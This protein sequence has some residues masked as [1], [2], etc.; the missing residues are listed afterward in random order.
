MS[1]FLQRVFLVNGVLFLGVCGVVQAQNPLATYDGL[2]AGDHLGIGMSRA[3]DVDLD[4]HADYMVAGNYD[5]SGTLHVGRVEVRSGKTGAMLFVFEGDPAAEFGG[6]GIAVAGGGDIDAD[7]IPD[8]VVGDSRNHVSDPGFKSKVWVYSGKDGSTILE[9][10]GVANGLKPNSLAVPGDVNQDG[11]A[12]IFVGASTN[13][14]APSVPGFVRVYS[15]KDG[16]MLFQVSSSKPKDGFGETVA[17]AG[18]VDGDG[19]SDLLIGVKN[20]DTNGFHAGKAL[21]YS[22]KTGAPIHTILGELG[23]QL[24]IS[25][26]GAGDLDADGFSDFIVGAPGKNG[27]KAF[28]YSGKDAS[29]LRELSSSPFYG[30]GTLFGH[31]VASVGDVN[32]DGLGDILVSSPYEGST[33]SGEPGVA[34]V[35]SGKDGALLFLKEAQTSLEIFGWGA[36]GVGDADGDGRDDFLVG[37][38]N[39]LPYQEEVIQ[40]FTGRIRVFS[41]SCPGSALSYGTGCVGS[42]GFV[43]SLLVSGCPSSSETIF[44]EM[45]PALDDLATGIVFV[46]AGST[47]LPLPNGCVFRVDPI[48]VSL[49]SIMIG[50]ALG[51][52]SFSAFN[53]VV[54]PGI[55]S[56]TKF[57]IQTF[58]FDSGAPGGYFATNGVHV[59]IENE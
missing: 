35:F 48:L 3:G 50:A 28:V 33:S 30:Y 52:G 9:L 57:T 32:G 40:D 51:A 5:A 59:A 37:S 53:L 4:G 10:S 44:L 39:V 43:P 14:E 18:D 49:P 1:S 56:G 16:S 7:G 45:T 26:D 13:N 46:G 24:G 27:G 15:G 31:A 58:V 34:R 42:D 38:L 29:V 17:G 36:A 19:V 23:A 12:D 54:P 55:P 20:D 8:F 6:F 22:G 11:H 21:V 2:K 41:G 47:E 25:L